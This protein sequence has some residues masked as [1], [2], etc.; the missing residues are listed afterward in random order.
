MKKLLSCLT[1][2][3]LTLTASAQ[4]LRDVKIR[5]VDAYE[6]TLVGKMMQTSNPYHR[7]DTLYYK[8]WDEV[9]NLQC[10]SSS[11]IAVAFKSDSRILALDY[12]I[13]EERETRATSPIS[14]RGFD[15]Y[16]K[17]AG[18]WCLVSPSVLPLVKTEGVI[19]LAKDMGNDMKEFLL[20]LPSYSDLKYCKIGVEDGFVLQSVENPFRHR[21]VF[22]G[23]SHTQGLG[24]GRTSM[25]YALQ[26]ERMTGLHV[27]NFGMAGRCKMQESALNVLKDVEADAFVFDAFSNPT[28][29]QIRA[30]LFP[31]IEALQEAHPGKP[32]IFQQTIVTAKSKYDSQANKTLEERMEAA[33][34]MMKEACKKY[35]DVYFIIPDVEAG[36]G[37]E[38]LDGTHID[39]YGHYLWAKSIEKPIIK[40]LKKYGIK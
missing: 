10:R 28:A 20:Y 24:T 31:F 9:E 19:T 21:I 16:V 36:A 29:E 6:L 35:K 11:G 1:V 4:K 22:H 27:L 5:Y 17:D 2:L 14:Y 18:K 40:I 26:F 30:R 37:R 25:N 23:S 33:E 39:N 8:G 7:V 12:S 13:R 38:T 15:L 32:L 3:L 34:K